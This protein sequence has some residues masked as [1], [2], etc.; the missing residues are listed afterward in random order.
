[1]RQKAVYLL[2]CKFTLHISVST[3]PNTRSTQNSTY[4]LRYWSYFCAATSLKGGQANLATLEGGSCL[5]P[6]HVEWTCRIINGLLC[7][8]V[9]TVHQWGLKHFIIQKMHRY[10]IRR[11]EWRLIRNAHSEISR[12]RDHVFKQT[13]VRSKVPYFSYELTQLFLDI[14]ALP[15][16]TF[17]PT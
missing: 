4:S 7:L 15:F 16:N 3:T 10:I 8:H 9:C 17:F 11:Y 12:K 2:F 6:K 1:M 14:V 13:K 5:T